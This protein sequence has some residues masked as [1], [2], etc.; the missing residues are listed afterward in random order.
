MMMV[1]LQFKRFCRPDAE[2][3]EMKRDAVDMDLLWLVSDLWGKVTTD[4]VDAAQLNYDR[5]LHVA[6][7]L[8]TLLIKTV[9][10]AMCLLLGNRSSAILQFNFWIFIDM[11]ITRAT[12]YI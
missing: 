8:D 1:H 9:R 7:L 10:G 12:K 4:Y 11:Y 3:N 5:I 6:L 2:P